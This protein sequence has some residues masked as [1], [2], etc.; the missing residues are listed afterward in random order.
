MAVTP[1][2]EP[3]LPWNPPRDNLHLACRLLPLVLGKSQQLFLGTKEG[4]C[5]AAGVELKLQ[6]FA[7]GLLPPCRAQYLFTVSE[8]EI[9]SKEARILQRG[10]QGQKGAG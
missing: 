3:D 1:P 4:L 8:G 7:E 9:M 10:H 2:R 6:I 5:H